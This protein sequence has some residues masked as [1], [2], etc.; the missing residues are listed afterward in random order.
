MTDFISNDN[1][2][3]PASPSDGNAYGHAALL[4]VESMLH[5]LIEETVFTVD[6]AIGLVDTAAEV[7]GDFGREL[8]EP[9]ATV[10]RSLA[11]LAAIGA[12]LQNDRR[13]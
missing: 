10:E 9:P 8:A 6:K 12:S 4:L 11:L 2:R 7:R 5:G 3:P 1:D 13:S